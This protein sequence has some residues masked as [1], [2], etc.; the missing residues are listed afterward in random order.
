M[1]TRLA[2]EP[3]H[4]LAAEQATLGAMLLNAEAVKTVSDLVGKE[5][6]YKPSHGDV[7]D[8]IMHLTRSG[9]PVDCLTVADELRKR[10]LL[11]K[12]GAPYL[13]DL[14]QACPSP[15]S[16]GSYARIVFDKWRQRSLITAGQQLLMLGHEDATTSEDVDRLLAEADGLMRMLGQESSTACDWDSLVSS[17]E[18][19]QQVKADVI[20][21]P[22]PELNDWF[23]GGG[24]HDGQLIIIGARPGSG[25]SN[26]G[27]NI[28]LDAA[29]HGRK[30]VVFSVEMDKPEV[31]SRLLAAGSY[32]KVGQLIAKKMDDD[33]RERVQQY[34]DT[35]KDMPLEVI[36]DPRITVERV[37]AHCRMSR[38]K[39]LFVDYTQLIEPTN[40]K[41]AREQ[42]VAHI[43]RSL[44]IAAKSLRMVVILASQVKRLDDKFS[45]SDKPKLPTIAD[46]RE[47]GAAEQDADVVILLHHAP[48]SPNVQVIIGKNRNGPTGDTV[49]R[50]RGDRARI[51]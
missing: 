21:T 18:T 34:I 28:A 32:S 3:P 17:W 7:F 15:L 40:N 2:T 20:H 10:S 35:H 23:P 13:L 4:D 24:F 39:V 8:C 31:A 6:F 27:L 16:A 44:K 48:N 46:L 49:L 42:Q 45:R 12:I 1:T 9:E 14:S 19:W 41:V 37:I 43:T 26:M 47:S 36:D 11:R 25:K 33:T 50:F 38:P 51:G 5:H 22:W 30:T 29:E